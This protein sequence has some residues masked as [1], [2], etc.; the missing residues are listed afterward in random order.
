MIFITTVCATQN[1]SAAE[2]S[3]H[4][5]KEQYQNLTKKPSTS[6][7]GIIDSLFDTAKDKLISGAN[8]VILNQAINS[9]PTLIDGEAM[10]MK[11][12]AF[13]QFLINNLLW[14]IESEEDETACNELLLDE[15]NCNKVSVYYVKVKNLKDTINYICPIKIIIKVE[16]INTTVKSAVILRA[17]VISISAFN[18]ISEDGTQEISFKNSYTLSK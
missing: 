6:S 9:V 4:S 10:K 13:S 7:I 12:R 3:G 8:L 18:C 11:S 1:I 5:L 16:E 17:P 2:G 14:K 15:N